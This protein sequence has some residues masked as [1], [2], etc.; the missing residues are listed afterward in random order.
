MGVVRYLGN[1]CGTSPSSGSLE[2]E[3]NGRLGK[4]DRQSP[5]SHSAM[6]STAPRHFAP[7]S[8]RFYRILHSDETWLQ[9]IERVGVSHQE[10]EASRISASFVLAEKAPVIH[11]KPGG[12]QMAK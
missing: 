3:A 11:R 10:L 8:R 7:S 5:L 4:F 12:T 6:Q 2:H 1:V 9:Y